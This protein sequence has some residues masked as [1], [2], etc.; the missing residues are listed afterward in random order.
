MVFVKLMG[1][2]GNQM[3][4]YAAGLAVARRAGASLRLDTTLLADRPGQDG[5]RTFELHRLKI[6]AKVA[7]P[8]E[9]AEATGGQAA[10]WRARLLAARRMAGLAMPQPPVLRERHFHFDPVVLEAPGHVYLVG[11]W[12]SERYFE[13]VRDALPKEFEPKSAPAGRNRELAGL[14]RS[15]PSVAVHVRRGD[16]VSRAP[17]AA[18][19]GACEAAYYEECFAEMERRVPGAA[20]FVFSDDPAWVREHMALPARATVVDHNPP[21]MAHEDLRLMSLC[22]HDIIANSSFSWWGAW[23]NANPG[24]VVLAPRRWFLDPSFDTSDLLPEGWIRV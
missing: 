20:Y 23:L 24:K 4:Q 14:V 9:L 11:Y 17:T 18:V 22:R 21:E 8:I 6:S 5:R 7:S 2:L 1:G 16:Y 3:F 12:Q 15:V 19:H 13:E 10:G